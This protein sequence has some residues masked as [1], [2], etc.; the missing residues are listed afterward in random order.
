M[1]YLLWGIIGCL[2][3]VILFLVGK[4]YGL[5]KSVKEISDSFAE[6]LE[7]ETNTLVTISSAD[8]VISE[9]ANDINQQLR[10][11]R[12]QRQK[13]FGGDRELKEAVTNIS[14]D[15]RTPLTA[16]CG[17]LN[18][19][20]REEQ[21]EKGAEYIAMIE[22]RTE[23]MKQLT[24]EM[25]RY[26]VVLSAKGELSLEKVCINDVLEEAIVGFYSAFKERGIEPVLCLTEK[27]VMRQANRE[28][29]SRV[30]EN[31]LN[32][33]LKYSD[34]DLEIKLAD[35]G[36][37]TFSNRTSSLDEVQVGRLFDRFFTVE[38]ARTS[39][40]LGLA[41]AKALVEEMGGRISANYKCGRLYIDISF[42]E[43][44]SCLL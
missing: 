41:I 7:I 9:F 3:I 17:Y 22:N 44:K 1:M 26:S 20:K 42:V 4:I 34:G 32:N 28:A 18:L 37:I 13:Y 24:E 23:A 12:E 21:S 8:P 6:K 38:T 33:A 19:L 15:L 5:R 29:L 14:H 16:I 2:C 43:K 10:I 35:D 39:T 31:V 25:F 11:L 30:F 40:G 27:A 36:M